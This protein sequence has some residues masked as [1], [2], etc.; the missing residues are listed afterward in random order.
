MR[1]AMLTLKY[2][3]DNVEEVIILGARFAPVG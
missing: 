3:M 2:S 1:E